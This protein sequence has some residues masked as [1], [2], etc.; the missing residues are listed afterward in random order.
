[1]IFPAALAASS[2][3]PFERMR[4]DNGVFPGV[5]MARA[6]KGRPWVLGSFRAPFFSHD[7]RRIDIQRI[8]APLLLIPARLAPS[9][10]PAS[11]PT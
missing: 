11:I 10:Y 5:S 6:A 4:W 9:A 1:M 7:L 2:T 3:K 8:L